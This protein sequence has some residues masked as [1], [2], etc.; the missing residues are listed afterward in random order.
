[1]GRG[2][3]VVGMLGTVG[4]SGASRVAAAPLLDVAGLG[5]GAQETEAR[6]R[7][8][9][10]ATRERARDT[11]REQSRESREPRE[12]RDGRQGPPRWVDAAEGP[13]VRTFKGGTGITLDL[14]NSYGDIVVLGNDGRE[15]TV[16]ATRRVSAGV[17][18]AEVQKVIRALQ[19]DMVQHGNRVAVR[20]LSPTSRRVRIDYKTALPAGTAL[21]LKNMQGNVRLTNL[22]G[23]VRVDAVAGDVVGEA[24]S[25]VR[26]L[27][28]MSGDVT[29]SRSTVDGDANLQ[30]VSGDVLAS[31]VA[32]GSLTLGSVSGTVHVRDSSSERANVRTV[33]GDI[34]FMA[35]PRKAG[36]Y[37][38]KTHAGN[39][40]VLTT[41]GR[42]FEFEAT[43]LRGAVT[44]DLPTSP[45]AP[46]MRNVRGT[47]GDGSA[48]FDLT[49]FAG[50]I[51][52]TKR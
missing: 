7:A 3:I 19:I 4:A 31:G 24:L 51:K 38:L 40:L 32:A 45:G 30:T 41:R 15:G 29:L 12:G 50:D 46:G 47:I 5:Q 52:I 35:L 25:R 48:F 16:Q 17:D 22:A 20:T 49:T 21:D 43:T 36:R 11:H 8:E 39:I 37:E 9:R 33:S 6:R 10:E 26:L 44:T 34:E 1:M 42:G 13:L 2:L 28:S 27:R 23:D 18:P 14:L